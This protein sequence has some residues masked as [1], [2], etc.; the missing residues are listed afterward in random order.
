MFDAFL[1]MYKDKRSSLS[2]RDKNNCDRGLLHP[3]SKEG[4]RDKCRVQF[5]P[6][7]VRNPKIDE[8]GSASSR[9]DLTRA[10]RIRGQ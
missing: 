3:T 8:E 9:A 10:V 1:S 5:L 4:P 2:L 7:E 6:F